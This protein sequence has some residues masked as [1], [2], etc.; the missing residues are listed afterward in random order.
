MTPSSVA[1]ALPDYQRRSTN[2]R[3][4]ILKNEEQRMQLEQRLRAL[5]SQSSRSYQHKQIQHIQTYF[6]RLNQESQRAEQRNLQLLNELSHAQQ[7]LD[8]LHFDAEHLIDLKNDY[9]TYLETNYPNWQKPTS[10]RSSVNVASST[11]F[12]RLVENMKQGRHQQLENEGN[13]RQSGKVAFMFE[14]IA[15]GF[16]AFVR[17]SRSSIVRRG[18]V[19]VVP[20]LRRSTENSPRTNHLAVDANAQQR[21]PR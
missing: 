9:L 17:T 7:R 10:M 13:L 6:N 8:R 19:Y 12:D 16:L 5:A 20:A 1:P 18:L 15:M 4:K 21:Q 3:S 11:E 14:F 2:L